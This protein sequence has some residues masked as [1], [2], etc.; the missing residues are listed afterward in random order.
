MFFRKFSKT[1]A[2]YTAVKA[3]LKKG[4]SGAGLHDR[5][6]TLLLFKL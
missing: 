2:F 3:T 5:V 4:C 6:V 1:E